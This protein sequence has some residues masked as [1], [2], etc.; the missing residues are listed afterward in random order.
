MLEIDCRTADISCAT[1]TSAPSRIDSVLD[2]AEGGSG[3]DGGCR[4]RVMQIASCYA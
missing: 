4:G 3:V 2:V 1:G